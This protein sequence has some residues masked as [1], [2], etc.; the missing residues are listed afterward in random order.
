MADE[1]KAK[2]PAK[3][4]APVVQVRKKRTVVDETHEK[5]VSVGYSTVVFRPGQLLDSPHLI[6]VAQS[7]GIA[8]REV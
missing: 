6:Q 4:V 2:E 3:E 5:Y 7:N 1:P 8:T